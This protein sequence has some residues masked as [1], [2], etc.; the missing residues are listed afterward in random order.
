MSFNPIHLDMMFI[1][2]LFAVF[3]MYLPFHKYKTSFIYQFSVFISFLLVG[4]VV[5]ALDTVQM[6]LPLRLGCRGRILLRINK[7]FQTHTLCHLNLEILCLK[8]CISH[9]NI[10][11]LVW[12]WVRECTCS[13][14]LLSFV[15]LR[16]KRKTV[17]SLRQ[18]AVYHQSC[19]SN[20]NKNNTAKV[21]S[22]VEEQFN[23]LEHTNSCFGLGCV[24]KYIVS[25]YVFIF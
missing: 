24:A 14:G 22:Q 7:K 2:S 12:F 5:Q 4:R 16:I 13:D 8:I 10:F 25:K 21:I 18:F 15:Y 3:L 9:F 6:V 19:V 1:I 20:V 17:I 23:I 11:Y